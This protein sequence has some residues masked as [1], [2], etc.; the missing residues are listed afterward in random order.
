MELPW[1]DAE[2]EPLTSLVLVAADGPSEQGDTT[3]MSKRQRDALNVLNTMYGEAEE[4]L[5]AQSRDP[6]EALIE[7]NAWR[8]ACY[9]HG[10]FEGKHRRYSWR[11]VRQALHD[12]HLVRIEGVHAIP[13]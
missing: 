7:V 13:L 8:D 3:T 5:L 11:D 10:I 2:E 9:A 6:S 12:R 1:K 4:I